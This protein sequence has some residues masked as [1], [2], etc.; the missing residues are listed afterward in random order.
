VERGFI[1]FAILE[2]EEYRAIHDDPRL[3]DIVAR[4][5]E[6]IG[7][8]AAAKDFGLDTLSGE[9]FTLSEQDGKVVLIDFWATWCG[10]CRAEIPNLKSYYKEYKGRGFEII[11]ISLDQKEEALKSY[12]EKENLAWPIAFSGKGW[13]D[14]TRHLY[15]VNSIPSYWLVD[16]QG[17]L[18]YFGLR[19][20]RLRDAIRELLDET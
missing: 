4:I 12:L 20:E 18:R 14:D 16:R 7:V 17:V 13:G 1:S 6:K 3:K 15:G 5:K 10:P 2:D 11:G 9:R 8:G 19:G